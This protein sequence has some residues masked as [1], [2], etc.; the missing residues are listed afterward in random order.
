M[1]VQKWVERKV[2]AKSERVDG[3][4]GRCKNL[5]RGGRTEGGVETREPEAKPESQGPGPRT[6]RHL[7]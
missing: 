5:S 4:E 7:P 6:A 2:R 1:E 3:K